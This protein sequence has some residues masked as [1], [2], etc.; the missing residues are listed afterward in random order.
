LLLAES[1][2]TLEEEK[3]QLAGRRIG[4][5]GG[6]PSRYEKVAMR[7][8]EGGEVLGRLEGITRLG[9][10]EQKLQK[11]NLSLGPSKKGKELRG[12]SDA[13]LE[14]VWGQGKVNPLQTKRKGRN[15]G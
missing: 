10:S 5:L 15:S 12:R 4:Q 8:L 1:R 13:N 14:K 3:K 9:H 7:D 2:G 6:A 11:R